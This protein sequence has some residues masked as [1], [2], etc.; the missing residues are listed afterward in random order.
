LLAHV[1]LLAFTATAVFPFVWILMN[2]FK[3]RVQ[4]F[5]IPPLWIFEPTLENYANLLLS[6]DFPLHVFNS[7]IITSASVLLALA[8]GVPAAYVFSRYSRLRFKE[9]L[10][11]FIFTIRMGP[12]IAFAIP[13]YLIF[14]D[15][16][17]LDTHL[18]LILLYQTFNLP[19]TI[20]MMRGFFQEVPV[21]IDE[22]ALIDG[23]SRLKA[24]LSVVLPLV[25]SGLFATAIMSV[26]FTWNEFFMASVITRSAARTIPVDMP[27]FIGL[28]RIHW[29]SMCAAASITAIPVLIFA[30]IVR[31]QLVRGLTLG[32]V[33]G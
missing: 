9:G 29:E 24:F 1:A 25:R 2:S 22:A 11:F 18:A 14:A 4:V 13:F 30:L 31:K 16:K 3:T 7:V 17:L 10:Y 6:G 33:K 32:S 8:L 23:C 26:I 19:F 5:A 20:W 15:L 21:D 27:A 28:T 12:A